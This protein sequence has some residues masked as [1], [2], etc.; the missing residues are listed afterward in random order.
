M[1]FTAPFWSPSQAS[2]IL[3][4]WDGVIAESR[5]DF[6]EIR[7]KYYGTGRAML[8]ED[9]HTLEAD[10]RVSLMRDL[11]ELEISGAM[12]ADI[13]IGIAEILQWV[14]DRDIPWAIVSRN[15][16]KSINIAAKK[17]GV[18]LPEV[19]IS[20]DCREFVKPDPRALLDASSALNTHPSQTLFIGDFI[21]DMMGARRAGMRGVLVKDNI[22][23]DWSE[24]LECSFNSMFDLYSELIS[25]TDIIAWEYQDTA[26]RL[27]CDFIMKTAKIKLEIPALTKPDITAWLTKAASLG[28]VNFIAPDINLTPS[29]WKLNQ[30]LDPSY[31]GV[32][33]IQ[34]LASFMKVRYPLV[35]IFPTGFD[36]LTP[37]GDTDKLESFLLSLRDSI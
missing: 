29:T 2:A 35:N 17:I 11:E 23:N 30:A 6:S 10:A 28:V 19:V 31:L 12:T 7:T 21:Y 34:P 4:D 15:C 22:P 25:P 1:S 9:S 33:I 24:W 18:E 13:V 20:R 3:F 27:G 36:A 37:P 5:L 16:K 8:L 26:G 14:N 32:P